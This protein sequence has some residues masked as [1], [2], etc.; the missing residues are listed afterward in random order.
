[1]SEFVRTTVAPEV[2]ITW[3]DRLHYVAPG[4]DV[5][6]Y[7]GTGD[8]AVSL[9]GV[10]VLVGHGQGVLHRWARLGQTLELVRQGLKVRTP[11]CRHCDRAA[12]RRFPE[13]FTLPSAPEAEE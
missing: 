3:S 11:M 1:M 7:P 12:R 4:T 8:H 13:L 10:S 9:C 2:G 5:E 6:R